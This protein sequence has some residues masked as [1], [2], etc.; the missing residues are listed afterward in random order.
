LSYANGIGINHVAWEGGS[1]E[2]VPV[3]DEQDLVPGKLTRVDAAGISAVLVKDGSTMYAIAATCSHLAG[4]LDEGT[5]KDG[6][7]YCPWHA[8]GFRMSDGCVM[9]S[10][11]VY[12]QPT[13]AVRTRNGK[14]ELRRLEHA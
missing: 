2:Y 6:V 9:N 8:S 5:Y 13:F 7:V 1:D 11:A 12:A 3:L 10:P 14:I 4:P